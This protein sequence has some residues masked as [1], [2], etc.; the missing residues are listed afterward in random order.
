MSDDQD[1][2]APQ[3]R[4]PREECIDLEDEAVVRGFEVVALGAPPEQKQ[5][6]ASIC[7]GA[8][9]ATYTLAGVKD[10]VVISEPD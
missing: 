3:L 5:R 9:I 2:P 8:I 1:L 6:T 7:R 4:Q 10:S